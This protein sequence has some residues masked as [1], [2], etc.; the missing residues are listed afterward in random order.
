MFQNGWRSRERWWPWRCITKTAIWARCGS[1]MSRRAIFLKKKFVSWGR[2]AGQAAVAASN[3]RL[4]ATAEIGRQRLEAVLVSTPEPVL[5]FDEQARL[6]LLNAAA[7]QVPGLVIS[8]APGRTSDRNVAPKELIGLIIQPQDEKLSSCK[9]NLPNGRVY[10][11]SVSAVN[12]DR[13]TGG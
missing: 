5:V 3:A 9:I 2:L 6:L 11:A 4:Y 13:P 8:A 10:F 1:L 12:A 7:L